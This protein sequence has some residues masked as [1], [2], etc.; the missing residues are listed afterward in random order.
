M[1]AP[2]TSAP[3]NIMNLTSVCDVSGYSVISFDVNKAVV[4]TVCEVILFLKDD[5]NEQA[6]WSDVFNENAKAFTVKGIANGT[7]TLRADNGIASKDYTVLVDCARQISTLV[8]DAVD[9]TAATKATVKD[10]KAVIHLAAA[11]GV[12][13]ETHL[14][15]FIWAAATE[16]AP[17]IY[18]I[19]YTG[20]AVGLYTVY[21][22]DADGNKAEYTFTI[23]AT[24][25]LGCTSKGAKN[26][27]PDAT[28]D[29]GTCEF[30]PPTQAA[31]ISI[32]I[33]SSLRFVREALLDELPNLDNRLYVCGEDWPAIYR[34]PYYQ[35]V[36]P[37]DKTITQFRSNYEQHVA[38]IVDYTTGQVVQTMPVELKQK[39]LGITRPYDAWLTQN[40]GSPTTARLFF[41]GGK[42]PY[43][44]VIGDSVNIK[45]GTPSALNTQYLVTAIDFDPVNS[46][47]Y[48]VINLTYPTAAPLQLRINVTAEAVYDT[49]PYNVYEFTPVWEDLQYGAYFVR[50]RATALTAGFLN[51]TFTTEPIALMPYFPNTHLITWRNYDD[52]AGLNFGTGL[53]CGLRVES[54]LWQ[55]LPGGTSATFRNPANQLI[56]LR[57]TMQRKAQFNTYQLPP[58]L[59]EKLGFIFGLDRI[60]INN[61]EYQTEDN[62]ANPSYTA[63]YALSNASIT[64]EQVTAFTDQNDT[65]VIDLNGLSNDFVLVN[66]KYLRIK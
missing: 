15:N 18:E 50:I 20:L 10:G 6:K 61:I 4:E 62:Y 13:V 35:K 48:L 1:F 8:I 9:T 65:D 46:I 37:T 54:D 27:N 55:R 32:S 34:P 33:L 59:H 28:D 64:V 25:V 57:S 29:D 38:E 58:W 56:K 22:R 49:Q 42:L 17:G 19:T 26:Y 5:P 7:Y 39:N 47:P 66:G 51:A 43:D 30:E 24:K 14:G 41:N 3:P 60:E 21:G 23:D 12:T 44:F 31:Y 52:A 2:G 45:N 36:C 53:V 63:R 40:I 11:A 16:T